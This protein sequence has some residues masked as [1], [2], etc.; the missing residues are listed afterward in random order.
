MHDKSHCIV[1]NTRISSLSTVVSA[2][3][4]V[5]AAVVTAGSEEDNVSLDSVFCVFFS[6]LDLLGFSC[7][8]SNNKHDDVLLLTGVVIVLLLVE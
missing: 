2:A 5:A 8:D 7:N 1:P 6:T 4:V 3:V